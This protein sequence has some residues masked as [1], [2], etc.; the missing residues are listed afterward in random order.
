MKKVYLI[1]TL[2]SSIF[3]IN[4]EKVSTANVSKVTS[5]PTIT[6]TG[7]KFII[8]NQGDSFTDP[9]AVGTAGSQ[10]LK[11]N[12][13]GTVDTKVI[14]VYPLTYSAK[15]DDGFSAESSRRVIVVSTKPSTIDL[16]GVFVRNGANINNITKI[17]DRVYKCDNAGGVGEASANIKLTMFFINLDDTKV[18]AP[19]QDNVSPSGNTAES[20]VGTIKSANE[21]NWYI[22]AAPYG[23]A[24]RTFVRK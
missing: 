17:S 18:Y 11:L 24:L 14:G 7:A 16:S 13:T 6:L 15:N 12:V 1:L 8:V 2:F 10:I 19:L 23:P 9:G 20:S 22:Y 3:F 21:F 5:Y 4:C